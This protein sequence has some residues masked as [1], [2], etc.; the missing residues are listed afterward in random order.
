VLVDM[1]LDVDPAKYKDFVVFEKGKRVLYV[2][3]MR[4]IYGMLQ[5]SLLWYKKFRKDLEE[6]GFVFNPYDP[7]VANKMVNGKQHTIR[8]HVDDLM[9]SHIEPGVN[10]ELLAWMQDKYGKF[11]DV[12]SHRGKE[13]DYLGMI[14]RFGNDGVVEID[15][16]RYVEEM[17]EEFPVKFKETEGAPTPASDN[18]WTLG[19]KKAIDEQRKEIYHSFVAKGLFLAKRARPDTMPT[20]AVLSTRVKDPQEGDWKKLVRLMKYLNGTRELTLKLKCDNLYSLKWFVDVAFGVHPD[21]KSHTG[22]VLKFGGKSMGAVQTISR[23]QKLNTRSSTE[24]ELV[25]ADDAMSL[26]LWTKSFLKEQGIEVKENIIY[27]D[28][29]S[30]ILLEENG[31]KSAGKRTRAL[32]IR[33]FFIT[34]QIE[35]KNLKVE[36]CPT[37]NMIGDFMTKPLQGQKF[38]D[39]RAEIMGIDK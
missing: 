15:M 25:G 32:N 1:L 21:F 34:D 23:K 13:H 29:K 38:K 17:L 9:A 33:Y 2:Q 19:P 10:D 36:F 8:F 3:V 6:I 28:N 4:A 11:G 31:R 35:K 12:T 14:M 7:C 16:K 22:A 27:Q 26:I 18:L 37:D 39:F 24:A 20:I 5:A 30:T